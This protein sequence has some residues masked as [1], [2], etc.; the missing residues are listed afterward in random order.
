MG[1]LARLKELVERLV[2]LDAKL[3]AQRPP[4]SSP[5]MEG[6]TLVVG[7][8][9]DDMQSGL[10]QEPDAVGT[11]GE[12]ATATT[13]TDGIGRFVYTELA[14]VVDEDDTATSEER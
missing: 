4:A 9:G 7:E 1:D 14:R 2:A 5:L 10:V 8:S 12:V 13:C 6:D 11:P 3:R